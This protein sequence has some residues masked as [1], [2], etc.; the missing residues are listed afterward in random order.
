MAAGRPNEAHAPMSLHRYRLTIRY[1]GSGFHGWQKQCALDHGGRPIRTVAGEVEAALCRVLGQPVEL[2]GASRTDAG[3]HALGQ[4]AAFDAATT[5]PVDRMALAVN[6]RLPADVEIWDV[7]RVD[8]DFHAIRSVV[9]KRYRY[10]IWRAERRPLEKRHVVWACR[11]P[12][13]L[14]RMAEGA[15]RLRGRHDLAGFAAASHGRATTVRTIHRCAVEAAPPD[16]IHVVVEGD[17]FLYHTVRIITGTLVEIGRGRFEPSRIDRVLAT[18]ERSEAG[19][20]L[21]ARGL[22]LEWVRYAGEG[23]LSE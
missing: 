20:T 12:L 4:V 2:L 3:V 14:G 10:R 11:W 5:I 22:W 15:R 23:P 8:F 16:E 6:A 19:P 17:G 13:D 21:P 1:D 9:S 7:R 18:A